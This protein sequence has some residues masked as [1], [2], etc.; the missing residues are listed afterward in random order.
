MCQSRIRSCKIYLVLEIFVCSTIYM[1]SIGGQPF[2]SAAILEYAEGINKS[3]FISGCDVLYSNIYL[4][5]SNVYFID[6][7]ALASSHTWAPAGVWGRHA[8]LPPEQFVVD[9]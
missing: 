8:W 4:S 9:L 6:L 7:R 2:G 5:S 3:D 1:N